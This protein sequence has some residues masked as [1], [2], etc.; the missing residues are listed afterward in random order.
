MHQIF[1]EM[2][3]QGQN[4]KRLST[5]IIEIVVKVFIMFLHKEP[6]DLFNNDNPIKTIKMMPI[7][8]TFRP[9]KEPY[10][11]HQWFLL[12]SSVFHLRQGL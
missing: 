6:A 7:Q 3:N 2:K 8:F 12:N 10:V 5:C 9:V 1:L 11:Q 4:Q